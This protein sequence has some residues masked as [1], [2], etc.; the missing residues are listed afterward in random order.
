[1]FSASLPWRLTLPCCNNLEMMMYQVP[2]DMSTKI[3]KV[4]LATKS[5]SR[6]RASRPYGFLTVSLVAGFG[7]GVGV[8]VFEVASLVAV[9]TGALLVSSAK[10]ELNGSNEQAAIKLAEAKRTSG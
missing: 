6:Q 5:P 2:I 3:N 10:T 7:G 9:A 1:M 8:L 4:D